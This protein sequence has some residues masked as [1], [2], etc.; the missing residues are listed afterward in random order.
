ML[1]ANV[2]CH[3]SSLMSPMS[4]KVAWCGVVDEDIDPA[5]LVG[6]ALDDHLAAFGIADV[7][8]DEDGL[9]SLFL[10]QRFHFLC[11]VIFAQVGDQD[12]RALSGVRDR[13]SPADAAVA[14]GDDGP[15]RPFSFPSPC[16]SPR[17][18]RAAGPFSRSS[19]ASA[20]SAMETVAW[21]GRKPL[22]NHSSCSAFNNLA[23][24]SVPSA[25]FY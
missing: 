5:E 13:D 20:A 3:S 2:I 21:G 12:V 24:C 25:A 4:L 22:Q 18:R 1:T 19:P 9:A 14:A 8:G 10:H 16:S 17:R 11:V 23:V 15:F 7:A 6:G